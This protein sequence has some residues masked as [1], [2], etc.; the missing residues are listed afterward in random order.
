MD[1]REWTDWRQGDG[2]G[3]CLFPQV[4]FDVAWTTAVEVETEGNEW[5]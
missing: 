1:E 3:G 5:T 2:Q 4:R